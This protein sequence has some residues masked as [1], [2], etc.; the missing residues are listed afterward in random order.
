MKREVTVHRARMVEGD[1]FVRYENVPGQLS[2]VVVEREFPDLPTAAGSMGYATVDRDGSII[3]G[4]LV[5]RTARHQSVTP[6]IAPLL[7]GSVWLTEEQIS[8]FTPVEPVETVEVH[9]V[10][11]AIIG[12]LPC[13]ATE[14]VDTAAKAVMEVFYK[15]A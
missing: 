14:N 1:R 10:K 9:D 13:M 7:E 11:C 3:G 5:I 2:S 4:V 12:A 8:D 15:E 6:W